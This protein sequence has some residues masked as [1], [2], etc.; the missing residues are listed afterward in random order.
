[1]ADDSLLKKFYGEEF[2]VKSTDKGVGV[3]RKC[4]LC[5]FPV[6]TKQGIPSNYYRHLKVICLNAL[7]S[8]V[9]SYV[10]SARFLSPK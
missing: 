6:K 10:S 9:K 4:K 2:V 1:M 8:Y 3:A 5:Q 7:I